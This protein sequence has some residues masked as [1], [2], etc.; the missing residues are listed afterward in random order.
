MADADRI[1]GVGVDTH[2]DSHYAVVVDEHGGELAGQRFAATR[3]GHADLVAW[4]GE[5][6]QVVRAGVEGTG[7]YGAA[8]ARY[9]AQVGWVVVEVTS[10][11]KAQRRARGKTDQLDALHAARVT[12]TGQ[13]CAQAK[14]TSGR[15]E[16][17]RLLHTER[18]QVVKHQTATMN[19]IHAVLVGA[20][21]SIRERV[22]GGG[23]D[24]VKA[25]LRLR[26]RAEDGPAGATVVAVLHRRAKA[27]SQARQVAV[28]LLDEI[29][30]LVTAHNP[31]LIAQRG[32]GPD[33]AAALLICVGENADRIH[34]PASFARLTGTAPIPASSGTTNRHRLSRG[35]D[36]QANAALYRIT[37]S[38][39]S[40][41]PETQAYYARTIA[42]GRSKPDAIR[43]IKRYLARRLHHILL[44]P[45]TT[46]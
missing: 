1:V 4:A 40:C 46:T 23:V 24:L 17:I 14:D 12:M 41:D 7:S 18:R 11:D 2:R 35:G 44:Q 26:V 29:G 22:S 25:C 43:L 45:A 5:F 20:P 32:V 10:T 38:R 8:L 13:A 42:R 33:S 9:L 19:L 28:E 6:G 21:V 27:W 16:R 31:T 3:A 34:D 30:E 15:V 36:R 37:I 39:L